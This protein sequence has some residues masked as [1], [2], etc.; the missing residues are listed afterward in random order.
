[1]SSQ[2]ES[3]TTNVAGVGARVATVK[4]LKALKTPEEG[5]TKKDYEDFLEKI[6]NHVM[7]HWTY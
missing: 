5:G 2:T 7:V 1:M 3:G 4:N 6:H